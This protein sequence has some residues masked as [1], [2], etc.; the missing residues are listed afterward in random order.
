MQASPPTRDEDQAQDDED[1][2]QEYEPPQEEDD[3]QGEMKIMKKKKMIKKF[4]AKDR[5]TQ[6]STNSKRSPRQLHPRWHS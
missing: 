6:E 3:D 4:R 5:H 1:E 2:D